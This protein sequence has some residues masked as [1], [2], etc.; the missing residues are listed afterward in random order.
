MVARRCRLA[1]GQQPVYRYDELKFLVGGG[2]D[3]TA[4]LTRLQ[5]IGLLAWEATTLTFPPHPDGTNATLA[6]MLAQIPN[7]HRRMP[8]PRRLLRFLAKGCSRV[9]L[10]TIL[11]H[12]FRCLYYRQ[13]RCYA[14]GFCKA[15]WIAEVFGVSLRA[16][17]TARHC[18]EAL[19]FLQRMETPQ[20]VRNHYGQ[21][22]AINL[23]WDGS[24]LPSSVALALATETAPPLVS[25][26]I[27]IAP[28]DSDKQLL[29]EEKY[30]KPATGG[31]TGVLSTLFTQARECLRN[32]TTLLEESNPTSIPT[33]TV[34][35]SIPQSSAPTPKTTPLPPPRLHQVIPADLRN[36]ERLLTLYTQA[37]QEC[38][39]GWSEAE[40]LAFVALAQH[41]LE[42]RPTNPGGLFLQLLR[43]RHFSFITQEEEDTARRRLVAYMYPDTHGAGLIA[44]A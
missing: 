14:E 17:K 37:V 11:G 10:A 39:I 13:G 6:A 23:H 40:R 1:A 29:S 2:G 41:V 30:Q 34:A 38:L 18:L 21:K 27:K 24:A 9:L 5:A 4:A 22:M 26:Q 31:S 8:V 16:V 44:A 7:H 25:Q 3:L 33:V 19:G 35:Q 42:F 43:Q 32:G 36:M 20:W 15:S 12:L 28:P